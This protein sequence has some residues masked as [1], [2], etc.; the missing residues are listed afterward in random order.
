ML[1]QFFNDY[2]N[3]SKAEQ[4]GFT[5]LVLLILLLAFLPMASN[6]ISKSPSLKDNDLQTFKL[7]YFS[8]EK[9]SEQSSN[10]PETDLFEFDPN[11]IS[12]ES[13]I[14]LGL[15]AYQVEQLV[16]YR[17]KGGKF[18]ARDDVLK[19]YAISKE[20][21]LRLRPFIKIPFGQYSNSDWYT[22]ISGEKEQREVYLNNSDSL[23]WV[24]LPGI[25]PIKSARIIRYRESIGGFHS[26]DQL[27]NV[28][29]IDSS[30]YES[31]KDKIIFDEPSFKLPESIPNSVPGTLALVDINQVDSTG[32]CKLKGIG[33]V[34][35]RRIINYR[36]KLGGF[37]R[38]EQLLEV[39][40]LSE[41]TFQIIIFGLIIGPQPPLKM[42]LN[43][44]SFEQ[45]SKHPYVSSSLARFII[46]YRTNNKGF[47]STD[48]IRNSF[49]VDEAVWKKLSPYLIVD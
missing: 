34:L 20:D 33:P 46:T 3:F 42:N 1:R 48:E 37:T 11:T 27:L 47:K 31:I 38:K 28:F 23:D 24:S 49:L 35:S 6:I 4:K 32:L 21:Y 26:K 16:N 45:L 8:A 25:G 10:Q 17:D 12:T 15:S 40:G 7:A 5:I 30:L 29:G 14:E 36:D 18:Y 39:Y 9:E 13:L 43:S 44:A 41:E 2:F 22:N 19:L